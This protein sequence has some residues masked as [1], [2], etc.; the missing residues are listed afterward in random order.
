MTQH[1]PHAYKHLLIGWLMGVYDSGGGRM[2]GRRRPS[3]C[4]PSL[5]ALA[6]GVDQVLMVMSP[7]Y[8]NGGP[9][10]RGRREGGI[11]SKGDLKE[12]DNRDR[13]DETA[14]VSPCFQGG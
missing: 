5:R 2:R 14:T 8:N 7:L 10:R 4:P 9:Q 13:G 12:G 1:L 6:H 3:T 11:A